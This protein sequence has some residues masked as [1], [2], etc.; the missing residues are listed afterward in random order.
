MSEM[1]K[2]KV[3]GM[4]CGHCEGRV[5]AAALSVSGVQEAKANAKK[6]EVVLKMVDAHPL[7]AVREAIKQAGYEV[8]D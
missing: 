2:L 6:N 3:S 4:H 8:G 5:N 1:I 7:P